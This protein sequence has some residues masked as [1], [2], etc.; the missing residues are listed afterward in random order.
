MSLAIALQAHLSFPGYEK[1]LL[2]ELSILNS[3]ILD[4]KERLVLASPLSQQPLW[5]QCTWLNPQ[6]IEIESINDASAKLKALSPLWMGYSF[7]LH[8]R[9]ELIQHKILRLLPKPLLFL[10]KPPEKKFGAWTLWDEKKILASA[11]TTSSLP[12]G[13]ATFQEDKSLPSRAY[14]KLWE[15]FTLHEPAPQKGARVIDLGSSPGG[16]TWVL[17]DLGCDVISVDKAALDERLL[18]RQNIQILKKDA[19]TLKPD[20]VGPV[21]IMFSDIICEPKRLLQLAETWINSGQCKKLICTIKFKGKTDF[22]ILQKFKQI[23][24]SRLIHLCA[25]KHEMTWICNPTT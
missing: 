3:K 11:E 9:A 13:L 21:D 1:E 23:P 25:N 17:S 19:F 8:R 6:W 14:L 15:L 18:Q 16:W 2:E 10:K 24:G 22:N 5:S 7:H 20:D 4:Q 12:L